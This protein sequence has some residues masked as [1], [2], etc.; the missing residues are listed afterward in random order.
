MKNPNSEVGAFISQKFFETGMV[1]ED[2][3]YMNIMGHKF[4][5]TNDTDIIPVGTIYATGPDRQ[6]GWFGELQA[7]QTYIKWER[8]KLR[9]YIRQILGRTIG[10]VRNVAKLTLTV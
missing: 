7:P 8:G 1:G 6:L 5:M 2:L 10:N 3:R 4:I 9:M